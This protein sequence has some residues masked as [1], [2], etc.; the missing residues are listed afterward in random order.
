MLGP[1]HPSLCTPGAMGASCWLWLV[2]TWG[3][4]F[5]T[6]CV[7]RNR[8]PHP[9]LCRLPR[10]GSASSVAGL[11]SCRQGQ[12]W[13]VASQEARLFAHLTALTCPF[14]CDKSGKPQWASCRQAS[15][16][17]VG[18]EAFAMLWFPL[19]GESQTPPGWGLTALSSFPRSKKLHKIVRFPL[20]G[21]ENQTQTLYEMVTWVCGVAFCPHRKYVQVP[22][23]GSC[24]CDLI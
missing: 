23:L 10:L 13:A 24:D 5:W 16:G 8:S 14:S 15:M 1:A 3:H 12:L 20:V 17:Q 18:K 9:G 11:G 21:P 4:Y 6:S 7:L 19:S 2:T 22:T